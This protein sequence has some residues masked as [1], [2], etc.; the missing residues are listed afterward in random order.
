[1]IDIKAGNIS[2]VELNK[3]YCIRSDNHQIP[4]I[5]EDSKSPLFI[6]FSDANCKISHA[7]EWTICNIVHEDIG[8]GSYF[9]RKINFS[10]KEK[11]KITTSERISLQ[12][13]ENHYQEIWSVFSSDKVC[14]QI[15]NVDGKKMTD[16]HMRR[17]LMFKMLIKTKFLKLLR[18]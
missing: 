4:C 1:M 5:Y 8:Y 6:I 7:L 14:D 10:Q 11:E 16:V 15:E 13:K 18:S 17:F 12:R 9:W 3:T 2:P